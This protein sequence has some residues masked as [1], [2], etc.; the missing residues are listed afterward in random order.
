MQ[1]A[2]PPWD[3]ET[4]RVLQDTYLSL[5]TSREYIRHALYN[6]HSSSAPTS[7]NPSHHVCGTIDDF[8]D[9]DSSFLA[10]TH[11]AEPSLTPADFEAVIRL[12]I[13]DWVA[14]VSF[15]TAET[16]CISI[17]SYKG[18]PEILSIVFITLVELWVA[19]A[20]DKIVVGQ[21]PLL[22]EYSPEI[23]LSL[24]ERLLIRKSSA[25]DHIKLV[26]T[27][28]EARHHGTS[29]C[30]SVFLSTTKDKSFAVR[31]FHESSNLKS[32][33]LDIEADAEKERK[34]KKEELGTLNKNTLTYRKEQRPY[35][36]NP[37]TTPAAGNTTRKR[38]VK[39]VAWKRRYNQ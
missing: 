35:R 25:L 15:Q 11:T 31:Y 33:K 37:S 38:G 13:D 8:L 24:L 18:N 27:Y 5:N 7:F 17:E 1:E 29:S 30:P 2:S 9:T 20:M 3:P 32:L 6:Q 39:S 10:V 21:I 12:G 16:A 14:H 34:E 4:L 26:H 22:E 28:L 36:T 19:N 23:P